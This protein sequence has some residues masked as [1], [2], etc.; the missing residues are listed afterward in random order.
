MSTSLAEPARASSEPAAG[1]PTWPFLILVRYR[2]LQLRN[3]VDQQ[4]KDAPVRA[5]LVLALLVL[6]WIGLYA[7]F[8]IVLGQIKR[9][10]LVALVAR[11]Q[12]FVHFFLV[13]AVMLAFS[14]AILS[15][16]SLFSRQE[17]GHLLGTPAPPRHVVCIKWLEGM[18]LSSWSFLL[19]GVPL[20]LA[21]ARSTD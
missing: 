7:V 21:V 11:K 20:M 17:A 10:E 16:G 9:Y 14:N 19:L 3:L 15:F 18:L 4:L 8:A 5:F 13:L 1:A 2:A 6:I 12:I